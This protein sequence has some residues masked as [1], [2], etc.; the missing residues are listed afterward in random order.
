MALHGGM[1]STR[2]PLGVNRSAP[3]GARNGTA[4]SHFLPIPLVENRRSVPVHSGPAELLAAGNRAPHN[5]KT[6]PRYFL[7]GGVS[8][9][10]TA[11]EAV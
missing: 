3:C 11:S 6:P 10:F 4:K 9:L 1:A 8:F 7:T 2:A 5:T